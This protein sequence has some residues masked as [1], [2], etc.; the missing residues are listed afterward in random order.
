MKKLFKEMRNFFYFQ[1]VTIVSVL[2][3][4][5][6][7][8]YGQSL[9]SNWSSDL[10]ASLEEFNTCIA[11][12]TNDCSKFM[13]ES[14]ETVYKIN[15]FSKS[16]KYMNSSEIATFLK[17]SK[18]WTTIGHAY[19]QSVLKQAQD[20]A[21]AKKAVVAT[22]TNEAGIGHVVVITPG[23]L[24]PSGSWGLNVPNAASFFLPQPGKSFVD[25][26]LAFAF[27]KAQLKDVVIYIRNY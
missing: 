23:K 7:S 9:N 24:Q 13:G 14:L 25:K 17:N 22:Y 2:L 15:D 21:N 10:K 16:G 4:I 18:H 6:S 5:A 27:A 3:F 1:G 19:D 8:T 20:D 11:T 12:G 26:S